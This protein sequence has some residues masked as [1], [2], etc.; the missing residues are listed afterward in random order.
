MQLLRSLE[1]GSFGWTDLRG[2]VF[3]GGRDPC[4][5]TKVGPTSR[6]LD[7]GRAAPFGGSPSPGIRPGFQAA[8]HPVRRLV[9]SCNCFRNCSSL[10]INSRTLAQ[11]WITVE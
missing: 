8:N 9:R 3:R 1:W 7:T 4:A 10:A 6:G 11:A 5:Q 2:R